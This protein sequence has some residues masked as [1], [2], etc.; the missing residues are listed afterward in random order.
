MKRAL[1]IL[2]L[3]LVAFLPAGPTFYSSY[4]TAVA[5]ARANLSANERGAFAGHLERVCTLFD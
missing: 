2:A 4:T 1:E 5:L 3:L